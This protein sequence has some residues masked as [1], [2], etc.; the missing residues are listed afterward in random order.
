MTSTTAPAETRRRLRGHRFYLTPAEIAA[1]PR[2]Y[3]QDG[4]GLDAIV[5]VHYFCAAGDWWIT[6]MGTTADDA[7]GYV[8]LA[9]HQRGELGY[10][11]LQELEELEARAQRGIPVPIIVE[12]DLYWTKTTIRRAARICGAGEHF[13]SKPEECHAA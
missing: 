7:F 11:N 6:E 4:K 13:C 10:I 1:V 2:I 8:R 3:A 12:R 9:G 5:H